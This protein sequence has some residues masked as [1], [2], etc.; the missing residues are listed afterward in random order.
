MTLD[1]RITF[2]NTL[3]RI[4]NGKTV[5][6]QLSSSCE[7]LKVPGRRV[8][9]TW[10]NRHT[11]PQV[12]EL[13]FRLGNLKFRVVWEVPSCSP[14]IGTWKFNGSPRSYVFG[15]FIGHNWSLL[16]VSADIVDES[17]CEALLME[18][19]WAYFEDAGWH[20]IYFSDDQ[21]CSDAEWRE[22]ER[23]AEDDTA[24]EIAWWPGS[25][26]TVDYLEVCPRSRQAC[27]LGWVGTETSG[28]IDITFFKC[29]VPISSLRSPSARS[30]DPYFKIHVC[31]LSFFFPSLFIDFWSKSISWLA[32]SFIDD[33]AAYSV[34]ITEPGKGLTFVKKF[35]A[36]RT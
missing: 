7:L 24:Y 14:Y 13:R 19:P 20:P 6:K 35:I 17:T 31:V 2:C 34:S 32:K 28:D 18:A 11:N 9:S 16:L 27:F 25:C 1:G 10:H 30:G 36:K 22:V 33:S 15:L 26:E 5:V 4:V 21:L 12:L 29:R 8:R 23:T 3:V